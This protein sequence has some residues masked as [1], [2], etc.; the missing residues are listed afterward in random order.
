MGLHNDPAHL[1]TP[2]QM[3]V[4]ARFGCECCGTGFRRASDLQR[5]G[6]KFACDPCVRVG[7]CKACRTEWA[8]DGTDEC[9]ACTVRHYRANRSE[10]L[11]DLK[12]LLGTPWG[13]AVVEL[14]T[15][16]RSAA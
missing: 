9:T 6:G 13:R 7:V 12:M 2:G 5:F 8:A 3:P 1:G 14:V 11:D 16:T 4:L 15:G 10:F